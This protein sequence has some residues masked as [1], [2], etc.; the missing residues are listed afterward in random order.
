MDELIGGSE[1]SRLSDRAGEFPALL[2]RR[3]PRALRARSADVHRPAAELCQ[4][5][6][7]AG[8]RRA[9]H[10]SA[11]GRRRPGDL[12]RAA[13]GRRRARPHR[14]AVQ[15]LSSRA[16][17]ADQQGASGV[18]HRD[19]GRLPFDALGRRVARRAAA[20][21]HRDRRPLRHE[22]RAAA[23][24][25]GRGHHER[26]RLFDR[27][28]QA[29]CRRLHHRALRQSGSGLHAIQL[30]LNRAIYMDER[31]RERGPRFA[32]VAADFAALADALAQV[33]LGDLGP[34]QAAAE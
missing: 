17:A 15:A 7:D 32:Q 29:L 33:P 28:Q 27:P 13:F 25:H 19:R 16:A 24:R 10:H 3:Q 23:A 2:C 18:R 11:R 21:G 6:L 4:H 31:R 22:L 1:R 14:G 34:F 30:E 9:R 8:G 5:A 20:A 12:S 26:A